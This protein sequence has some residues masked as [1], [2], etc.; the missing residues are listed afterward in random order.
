MSYEEIEVK[1]IIDDLQA[2]R[3]RVVALGA[4]LLVPRTHEDNLRFDT[5]DARLRQQGYLLRL[6]HDR[7]Q[8]LTFKEPAPTDDPAFK[9]RR[10]YEVEV[11]DFD[12]TRAV[13]EKLG[14]MP[15]FRYEKY[16]ET[17]GYQGAEIMLDETPCG[18]FVEI[19]ASRQAIRTL[20]AR[21]DLD[22]EARLTASYS[23]IFE[24]VRTAYDLPFRDL[25][26]DNFR[27]LCID[28]R[29]CN[30]T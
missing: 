7:R 25:T 1:F 14:F 19:E 5:D 9:V 6:R 3:Q 28:L 4:R 22:F 24:A 12:Q 30:L 26:F 10:E 21:L 2:T 11:S 17:F 15:V 20:A 8:V 13:L 23:E 29:A 18:T 16:R 27:T